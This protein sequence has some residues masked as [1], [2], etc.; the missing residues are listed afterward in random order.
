MLDMDARRRIIGERIRLLR[1]Q[2]NLR[3]VDLAEQI[4][5]PKTYISRWETGNLNL[6]VPQLFKLADFFH[7]TPSYILGEDVGTIPQNVARLIRENR[8]LKGLNFYDIAI[9]TDGL[10]KPLY[11]KAIEGG[12]KIPTNEELVALAKILDIDLNS[13]KS[14]RECILTRIRKDLLLLKLDLED[15]DV[16]GQHIRFILYEREKPP[17]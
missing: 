11:M 14:G 8:E 12:H 13:S 3:Q 1:K 4:Q 6:D 9:Q 15:I 17:V 16:I 10:L 5:E 7:V 2:A